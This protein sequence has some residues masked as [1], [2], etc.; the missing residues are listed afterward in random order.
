MKDAAHQAPIWPNLGHLAG[1]LV[2]A[3]LSVAVL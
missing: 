2:T 3:E 1:T